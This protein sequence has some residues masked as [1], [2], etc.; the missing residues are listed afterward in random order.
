MLEIHGHVKKQLT[1]HSLST[2]REI[3]EE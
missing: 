3:A 2:E 1:N